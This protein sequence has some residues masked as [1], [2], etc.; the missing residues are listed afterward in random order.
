M[1]IQE[2]ALARQNVNLSGLKRFALEKLPDGPLRDDILSQP[3][4]V[5]LEEY[6]ANCRVWLRLARLHR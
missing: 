1:T 6:L 4:E 2:G 5:S 3:D